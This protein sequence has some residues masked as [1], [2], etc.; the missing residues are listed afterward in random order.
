MSDIANCNIVWTINKSSELDNLLVCQ[1]V[2]RIFTF[3]PY[4]CHFSPLFKACNIMPLKLIDSQLACFMYRCVNKFMPLEFCKMFAE[5]S[6][7]IRMILDLQMN[8]IKKVTN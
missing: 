4:K 8:C 5:N 3:P 7:L 1:K 2:V 6:T